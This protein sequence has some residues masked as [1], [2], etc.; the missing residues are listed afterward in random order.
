[1]NNYRQVCLLLL[2]ALFFLRCSSED[3]IPGSPPVADAGEDVESPIDLAGTIVLSASGSS[4]PDG[5]MLS[6][7][8]TLTQQPASST[9]TI[10]NDD[11]MNA[12][13]TPDA[14]GV[15][16]VTLE[17]D[18]GSHPPA[19]D[20]KQITI[21]EA[22]NEAPTA[23]AGGDLSAQV[24]ETVTLDGSSS[25]DP[26][27]DELEYQWTSSSNPVGAQFTISNA[28]QAQAT[29]VP[30]RAGTYVFRLKVTDPLGASDTD[31][32]DVIVTE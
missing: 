2:P 8:W 20:E 27:G 25:S 31:N 6:Y 11:E 19:R 15:Y 3:D 32:V 22:V 18:D 26:N 23:D 24:N 21:T 10:N 7:Q 1:M 29:F 12:S 4:D 16:L 13:I 17:V 14:E 30:D 28:D 9:A 5:D